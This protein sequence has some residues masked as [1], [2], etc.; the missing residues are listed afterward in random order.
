M[1]VHSATQVDVRGV[2]RVEQSSA[3]DVGATGGH[4]TLDGRRMIILELASFSGRR[5]DHGVSIVNHGGR[6]DLDRVRSRV[7]DA[8]ADAS[9]RLVLV[10]VGNVVFLLCILIESDDVSAALSDL[11][12]LQFRVCQRNDLLDISNVLHLLD[13]IELFI[14]ALLTDLEP[15]GN[16]A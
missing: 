6:H 4:S 7:E 8:A 10:L 14:E 3:A 9:L 16:R 2:A 5:D 15:L 13:D 12:Q 11:G 1:R